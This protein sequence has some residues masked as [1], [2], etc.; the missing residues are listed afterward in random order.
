MAEFTKG[1]RGSSFY[2]QFSIPTERFAD[3]VDRICDP[4]TEAL[5]V[6]NN[7]FANP[8]RTSWPEWFLT[9]PAAITVSNQCIVESSGVY[10]DVFVDQNNSDVYKVYMHGG[11]G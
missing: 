1:F 3:F 7:T 11:S 9:D 10:V 5:N 8:R 4:E 6:E 2:L